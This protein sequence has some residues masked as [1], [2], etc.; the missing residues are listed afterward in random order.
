MDNLRLST[1]T[2]KGSPKPNLSIAAQP[3]LHRPCSATL[4]KFHD[5]VNFSLQGNNPLYMHSK[6]HQNEND[7]RTRARNEYK[8]MLKKKT[9]VDETL[10]ASH[11]PKVIKQIQFDQQDPKHLTHLQMSNMTPLIHNPPP[12]RPIGS[13]SSR[14]SSAR[15]K[16]DINKTVD[17]E[18]S[19]ANLTQMRTKPWKP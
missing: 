16:Q 5:S 18:N 19:S 3:V 14:P 12:A 8:Y 9:Y 7:I 6:N 2:N 10:F 17:I 4:S 1:R 11:N 13:Y 15:A